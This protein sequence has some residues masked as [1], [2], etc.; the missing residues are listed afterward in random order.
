MLKK[1][2]LLLVSVF[3]SFSG[4]LD[5][6]TESTTETGLVADAVYNMPKGV[7]D[8]SR[9]IHDLHMLIM[10]ICVVVGALVFGVMF[11]A[12]IFHRKSRG[13]KPATF[14]EN[15]LV[16]IIW[17]AIPA[18][19]LIAMIFPAAKVLMRMYDASDSELTVKVTGYQ[20]KWQY[21]YLGEGI[22]FMSEMAT[23]ADQRNNL[24]PKGEFYLQE[25]TEP[26]VI[27]VDTKVRF[28]VTSKD[29]IHSWWVPDFAVKRDAIPGY[30]VEAWA[31]V[32]EEGIYRGECAELCG[33]EHAAMPV[34]VNVV[35]KAEFAQYMQDKRQ[36]AAEIAALTEKT[37][38]L[39][40][41]MTR[42][43]AAYNTSCAACHGVTGLGVPGAFPAMANSPVVLGPVETHIDVIVNGIAGTG[44]QAFGSQ[45][46]E[47]DMAAIITYERNAFGNDT[48]DIVQPIDIYN[49]NNGQ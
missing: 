27:P 4:L 42:G 35:S 43:E 14:H 10:W 41:L 36:E 44:M 16:E 38:T 30:T 22:S 23:P 24:A 18:V 29:V 2:Q 32:L 13:H 45:L 39:D 40:E 49:F 48:G 9:D 21:E 19:I 5:A 3:V 20:W 37:F 11:W 7:T 6:A 12:L 17:T 31:K 26:L 15:T 33:K 25:V 47:V 8:I 46:N 1:A 28:L 34:V